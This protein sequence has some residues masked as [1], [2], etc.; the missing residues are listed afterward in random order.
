LTCRCRA[1]NEHQHAPRNRVSDCVFHPNL[2][3]RQTIFELQA[4]RE[5]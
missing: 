2:P 1:R 3:I 5:C 4:K